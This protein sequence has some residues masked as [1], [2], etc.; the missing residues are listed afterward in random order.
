MENE[1]NFEVLKPKDTTKDIEIV[2]HKEKEEIPTYFTDQELNKFFTAIPPERTRDKV[3]FLTLLGTGRRVS[4]ILKIRK[5]DINLESRRL[6]IATLK[7]RKKVTENIR[8]HQDVAYWLSIYI[9][10]LKADDK[11]FNFTRQYADELIKNYAQ[12]AGIDYKRTS[13]HIFRHT[14]AVRW[15]EQGKPIHK[16]RR[17]LGH[18]HIQTTMVYLKIVDQDYDNTVDGLNI[19]S[20]LKTDTP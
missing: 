13:C 17:H 11:V 5:N 4:E 6:R 1:Q 3:F 19:L 20:F 10:S 2:K 9:G 15:L 12:V 18:S 8:L 7:K 16:L 14:F